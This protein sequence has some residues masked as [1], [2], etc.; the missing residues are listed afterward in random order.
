MVGY[1]EHRK[2]YKIFYPSFLK[3][4][5]ERSVQFEEAPMQEAELAQG[6]YSHPSVHD[7]VSDDY[8]SDIS[9]SYIYDDY[10]Y[11]H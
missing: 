1:D 11:M 4:F 9:D 5:I 7:D 10:F 2:G 3:T 6:D 8:S